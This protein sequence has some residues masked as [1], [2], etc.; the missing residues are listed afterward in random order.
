MKI[1]KIILKNFQCHSNLEIDFSKDV[2]LLTGASDKGKS[3]IRRAMEWLC[4]NK[5]INGLRKSGT[6]KTEVTIILNNGIVI[7]RIRT[8]SIN[9]Y[10]LKKKEGNIS[11]FDSIG[12]SIPEEIQNI[13]N[14][15]PF[16][17]DDEKFY[18][19][20]AEQ[21][22]L[23]FLFDKSPTFRAKLFNKLTGNEI[24]DKLL[25]DF[26]KDILRLNR[27]IKKEKQD[28]KIKKEEFEKKGIEKNK[29]EIL[30]LRIKNRLKKIKENYC[31]YRK[32]KELQEK[33][34]DLKE[35]GILLANELKLLKVIDIKEVKEKIYK[36]DWL[37]GWKNGFELNQTALRKVEDQLSEDRS[38]SIDFEA[39]GGQI[40]RYDKLKMIEKDLDI[41]L[42]KKNK[43]EKEISS[44]IQIIDENEKNIKEI[45]SKIK[46]CPTC[47]QEIKL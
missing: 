20:S 36:F 19:N 1:Q 26:N 2:N 7:S 8:A 22:S 10:E 30:H 32:Y 3:S 38:I 14:I 18:L 13:I 4:F 21:L 11:T 27:D 6:K 44:C 9:R 24:L 42:N 40:G 31:I 12:K 17:I 23:P 39:F 16:E 46:I 41:I 29:I 34:K 45:K 25:S 47:K 37:N 33:L 15:F 43:I 28:L 5:N 35:N